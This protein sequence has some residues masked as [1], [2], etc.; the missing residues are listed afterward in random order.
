MPPTMVVMT[1][2]GRTTFSAGVGGGSSVEL[3]GGVEGGVTKLLSPAGF[4]IFFSAP[5]SFRD[6]IGVAGEAGFEPDPGAT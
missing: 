6:E 3:V 1:G 4:S 5:T 2:G